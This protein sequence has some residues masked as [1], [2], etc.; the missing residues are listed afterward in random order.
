MKFVNIKDVEVEKEGVK[1]KLQQGRAMMI[2]DGYLDSDYENRWDAKPVFFFI[3]TIFDKYI[4]KHYFSKFEKWLVNDIN[5]LHS[6]VQ[7]FLNIYRYE[8]KI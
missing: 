6:R 7:R 2:F 1:L 5:D 3:R 4:F 8:K